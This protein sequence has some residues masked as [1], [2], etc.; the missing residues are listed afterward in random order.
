MGTKEVANL[1]AWRE[2]LD[3]WRERHSRNGIMKDFA[4]HVK[5]SRCYLYLIQRKLLNNLHEVCVL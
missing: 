1:D 2:K 4:C 5:E 3:A